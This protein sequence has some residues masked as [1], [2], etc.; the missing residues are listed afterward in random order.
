MALWRFPYE[1]GNHGG[2]AFILIYLGCVFL[3]G[4]PI[5]IAEFVIGRR[6]KASTGEA[7][8]VLA[9]KG[10]WK[11]VGYLGVLTG[12]LILGYYSVVSGWTL[13]YIF[14]SATGNLLGKSAD[15]F[16]TQ[17]QDFSQNPWRPL[18][19]LL[20]FVGMTHFI[21]VKGVQRGIECTKRHRT[22]FENHDANAFHHHRV[23]CGMCRDAS[24]SNERIGILAQARL[25][26]NHI[27]RRFGRH[28][29]SVL[30]AEFGNGMP[31]YLRFLL[32]P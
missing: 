21:I 26:Q 9:P 32:Q 28:G 31:V 29:T 3:F 16:V 13:E 30:L 8:K 11:Y 5:M 1:T 4:L 20:A 23:A 15:D 12:F 6:A 7:F 25:Q 17:F 10:G 24:R 14:Q 2:A 27:R 22:G 19:W 18:I